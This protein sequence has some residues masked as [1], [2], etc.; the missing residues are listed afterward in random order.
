MCF[1]L[2]VAGVNIICFLYVFEALI[3]KKHKKKPA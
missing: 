3:M 1:D 2:M